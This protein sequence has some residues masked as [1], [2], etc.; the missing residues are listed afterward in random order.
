MADNRNPATAAAPP[1]PS[2]PSPPLDIRKIFDS[3]III[4]NVFMIK[5]NDIIRETFLKYLQEYFCLDEW[6]MRHIEHV[7]AVTFL[8]SSSIFGFLTD[9]FSRKYLI[10]FGVGVLNVSILCESFVSAY[11]IFLVLHALET[12]GI[13]CVYVVSLP[14]LGDLF[15]GDIRS[16]MLCVYYLMRPLSRM[17]VLLVRTQIQILLGSCWS[18]LRASFVVGVVNVVLGLLVLREPPR[19]EVDGRQMEVT[20]IEEDLKYLLRNRTYMMTTLAL[21][22]MAC[23]QGAL[24]TLFGTLLF[25]GLKINNPDLDPYVVSSI[26]EL[27]IHMS[28]IVGLLAA[29]LI[30]RKLKEKYPRADPLMCSIALLT[31]TPLAIITTYLSNKDQISTYVVLFFG[32]VCLNMIW[33]ITMDICLGVVVPSRKGCAIG[34]T[35]F[36][37]FGLGSTWSSDITKIVSDGLYHYYQ[38]LE[39]HPDNKFYG[40]QHACFLSLVGLIVGAVLYFAASLSITDDLKE[41]KGNAA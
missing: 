39:E 6:G 8:L 25:D 40:L 38:S 37:A 28:S 29:Y 34:T 27:I 5:I 20:P 21:T 9:R 18:S 30:S 13:T 23:C 32:N 26:F 31:A 15:V 35:L 2:S 3:F 16:R 1:D 19:G 12:L 14:M 7:F 22:A 41:A 4:F 11:W 36:F 24:T 10:V 17:I 33:A